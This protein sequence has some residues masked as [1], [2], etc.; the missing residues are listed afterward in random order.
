MFLQNFSASF[1]VGCDCIKVLDEAVQGRRVRSQRSEQ[2]MSHKQAPGQYS[3][4]SNATSSSRMTKKS[5]VEPYTN[6]CNARKCDMVQQI[7]LLCACRGLIDAVN[8]RSTFHLRQYKASTGIMSC[9]S[10]IRPSFHLRVMCG[11]FSPPH[12][13][14]SYQRQGQDIVRQSRHE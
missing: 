6:F 5:A 1:V 8:E 9:N 12:D 14:V 11:D 2:H 7:V 3:T 13:N 10:P 4:S